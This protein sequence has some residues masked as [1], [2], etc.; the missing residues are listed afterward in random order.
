MSMV[1]GWYHGDI[2]VVT[3]HIVKVKTKGQVNYIPLLVTPELQY[4][5]LCF[6]PR[7]I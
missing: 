6:Q 7:E 2:R 4:V 5:Q 3:R 1:S